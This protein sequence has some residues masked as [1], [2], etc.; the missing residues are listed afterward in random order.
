VKR[1]GKPWGLGARDTL[2][3]EAAMPLYGHELNEDI[4]P[5]QAGVG[6]AVKMDK[7]DFRGKDPLA[8]RQK[9][10]SLR[11][12]VGL[13]LKGKR[14]AREGAVIKAN[15]KPIGLVTSGTHSPTF[16]RPIAM[17]YVDPAYQAVGTSLVID[18]RGNDEEAVV[19]SMPFYKRTKT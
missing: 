12:R 10:A 1:G 17:G 3:L 14:I 18:I 13:E 15:G 11:R 19:V 7:G 8:R 2:R 5:F 9:D 6:W 4:D 16:A